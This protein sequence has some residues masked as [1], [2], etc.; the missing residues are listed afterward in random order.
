[1][2]T[3]A[4][5][6]P[7]TGETIESIPYAGN[8]EIDRRLDAAV[9]VQRAWGSADIQERANALLQV[10]ERLRSRRDHLAAVAVREMGKPITQA[11]AEV[12]KMRVVLRVFCR[13]RARHARRRDG[14]IERNAQLR[15]VSAARSATGH[16]SNT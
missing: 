7:S 16:Y 13:G 10:A 4:T 15:C 9:H 5:V 6:N 1:M 11:R 3:I 2:D 14:S 8:D 12:E